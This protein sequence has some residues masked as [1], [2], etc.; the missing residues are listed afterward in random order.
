MS[1]GVAGGDVQVDER[2]GHGHRLRLSRQGQRPAGARAPDRLGGR[3]GSARHRASGRRPRAGEATGRP[4]SAAARLVAPAAKNSAHSCS[5]GATSASS[6]Q[7]LTGRRRGLGGPGPGG[8]HGSRRPQRGEVGERV[9]LPRHLRGVGVGEPRPGGREQRRHG[10]RGAGVAGSRALATDRSGTCDERAISPSPAPAAS[11]S[12]TSRSRGRRSRVDRPTGLDRRSA[13]RHRHELPLTVVEAASMRSPGRRRQVRSRAVRRP[14]SRHC[15]APSA[16][17]PPTPPSAPGPHG[18]GTAGCARGTAPGPHPVA[19]PRP[20]P[21]GDGSFPPL[22][23]DA[24]TPGN[25]S[26]EAPGEGGEPGQAERFP[27]L[28]PT[29]RF[30][31]PKPYAGCAGSAPLLEHMFERANVNPFS[32]IGESPGASGTDTPAG[33]PTEPSRGPRSRGSSARCR[34]PSATTSALTA[35]VDRE[36]ERDDRVD[37]LLVEKNLQLHLQVS[38]R[39]GVQLCRPTDGRRS[40]RC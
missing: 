11:G 21:H 7:A 6:C 23:L 32:H 2:I 1:Q 10:G 8:Q 13:P 26:S 5:S 24:R 16:T 9:T 19:G 4:A 25:D 12:P 34:E 15:S 3:A 31:R 14:R 20:H 40:H 22:P 37:D 18:P 36:G 35:D 30:Q 33:Q 28:R 39:V 27:T 38:A 17:R 29:R